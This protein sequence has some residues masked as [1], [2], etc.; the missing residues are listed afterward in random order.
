MENGR[1]TKRNGRKRKALMSRDPNRIL[2]VCYSRAVAPLFN[3]RLNAVAAN[4]WSDEELLQLEGIGPYVVWAV[5]E[6][7][8]QVEPAPFA[9]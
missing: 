6:S 3:N 1:E 7:N 5:R 4:T 9:V 8:R 2:R